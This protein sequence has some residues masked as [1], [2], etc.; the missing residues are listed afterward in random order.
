AGIAA[1]GDP[2]AR[3][4]PAPPAGPARARP[5]PDLAC[6]RGRPRGWLSASGTRTGGGRPGGHGHRPPERGDAGVLPPPFRL[7]G[8]TRPAR[9]TDRRRVRAPARPRSLLA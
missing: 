1:L 5:R 2:P 9:R 4:D 6:V 7:A 3:G 8:Q